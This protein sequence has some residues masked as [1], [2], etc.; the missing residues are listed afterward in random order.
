MC[1]SVSGGGAGDRGEEGD[2]EIGVA[3]VVVL[4]CAACGRQVRKLS[5]LGR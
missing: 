2:N 3:A 5:V 4:R 1:L